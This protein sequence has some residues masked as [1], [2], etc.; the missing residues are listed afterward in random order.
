MTRSSPGERNALVKTWW[1]ESREWKTGARAQD[2]R[3]SI[4]RHPQRRDI[5]AWMGEEIY[6][7]HFPVSCA[8][9]E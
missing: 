3:E 4:Q 1:K 6:A 9:V 7:G 2:H 8:K 5:E